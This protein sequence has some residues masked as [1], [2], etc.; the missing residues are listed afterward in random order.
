MM[1]VLLR[2][3]TRGP[4]PIPSTGRCRES[5]RVFGP[6][7]RVLTGPIRRGNP[8]EQD[9]RSGGDGVLQLG[10]DGVASQG[11]LRRARRSRKS[12]RT[13]GVHIAP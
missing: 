13:I 5:L 12:Q 11:V 3:L 9:V 4:S 1:R 2:L 7:D 6:L 8:N 10:R